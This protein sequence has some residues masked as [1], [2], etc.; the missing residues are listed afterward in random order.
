MAEQVIVR[1]RFNGPPN[2]AQGGYA[3]GVVAEAIEGSAEVRLRLPPPL[4]TPLELRRNGSGEVTLLDGDRVVAEGRPAEL[5]LDVPAPVSEAEARAGAAA[6]TWVE[7]HPFPTC[8]GCG[9]EREPGDAIR[10][11]LGPVPGREVVAAPWVPDRSL[12]GDG[13]E[14]RDVFM[15]AA[16]DCPTSQHPSLLEGCGPAVLGVMRARIDAP[17]RAGEPHTVIAWTIRHD[18]RRHH[19]GAAIHDADGR[20]CGVAEG[21]WVELRDPSVV[22][23]QVRP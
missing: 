3:C 18:G 22:D 21:V 9:P 15:W 12:A 14:V 16:L 2:S 19:G 1:R 7:R 20:L 4:E 5:A 6:C 11:L 10:L 13:E 8:F 17:A 23:A